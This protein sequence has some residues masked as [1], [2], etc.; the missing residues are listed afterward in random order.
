MKSRSEFLTPRRAMLSAGAAILAL[1][2]APAVAQDQFAG[3]APPD[4]DLQVVDESGIIIRND[5]NPNALPPAGNLD[6]GITGVGQMTIRANPAN[7]N[8]NLCTGTLI[9][10]RV[11]IFAAHCVNTR[12]ASAYGENGT[13]FGPHTG[14]TPIAFG[15]NAD[16][17]PAVR[18]WLGLES[19]PG[20]G[21][22]NPALVGRTNI[23][24]AL[25][26]VEQVWWDPRS[27]NPGSN[28]FIIGDIALATLDT[29]AFDIPTWALL[30]SPLTGPTDALLIGYG[31][32]GNANSPAAQVAID[33]RRRTAENIISV[34]GS[35]NDRNLWL[36]GSAGPVNNLY[37]TSFSDP[38]PNYNPAAGR[39]DFGV[40]GGPS[41]GDAAR[42]REGTTSGGDSGGPLVVQNKYDQQV[43]A[44]V[45]S[46]GSRFFAAQQFHNYGT[47]D[48]FQ[49]LHAY[50]DVIV[51]NNSYVYA[52]NKG[53]D[54][55]WEDPNH[56]VQLMDPAYMIDVNGQLVNSLP[57]TAPEG[58]SGTGAK[59]GYICFLDDCTQLNQAAPTG[60]GTPF[61]VEGGP[62]S[63]N[64]VPNNVVANPRLGIRSRYYDVTLSAPGRTTLSS[65]VTIDRMTLDGQTRLDVR[66]GGALNVLGEFNQIEGWTNVDGLIHSRR[67]AFFLTGLLSGTGTLRA[68]F[69]TV[70]SAI[71][72]PGGADRIGTLT[73]D[74]NLILASASALF[75]DANRFG[76]DRLAVTGALSINGTSLVMNKAQ[77]AAP[78]HGDAFVIASA[79]N[80]VTGTFGQIYAFQGVLRPELTYGPNTV[81]ATLRAGSL[82]NQIGQSGPT[83]R[84]FAR[85]LD[86]LRGNYYTSLYGLYGMVDLMSPAALSATLRGLAPTMVGETRTLQARQSR[87][88]LN[89]VGDRLSSLGS[90]PTGRL[91]VTG[92]AAFVGAL[93]SGQGA[94][95]AGVRF[96]GLV[97]SGAASGALPNGMTGFVS[98]GYLEGGSV[99]GGDRAG[100]GQ[101]QRSWHVA[102]GLEVE[103]APGFTIGSAFGFADGNAVPGA[104]GRS[105]A[106]TTQAAAYGSYRLGG[107]AYVAGLASAD[108]SRSYTER[109]GIAP[110]FSAT[111]IGASDTARYGAMVEAG[112]NLDAWR[113]LTLTPRAALAYQSVH[114]A[115]FRERGSETALQLDDLKVNELQARFGA[116][117]GGEMRLAGGWALQPQL[118]GDY[119]RSL[120]GANA[121]MMVRFANAPEVAFALPLVGGDS[122]WGELRGG[123]R[124]TNGSLSFGAGVET[125]IGRSDW[126]D[127][128]AVADVAFRF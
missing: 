62:G 39:F 94:D 66:S 37:M 93:A 58:V 102:M 117:L 40:F 43:V 55:A 10:P 97:P 21:D 35:L 73:V 25:Y 124:L 33:W 5:I 98:S 122:Q 9:N 11:V 100:L 19:T 74:G 110:D 105:E 123:L 6:S 56:W 112:V 45:L 79:G 118:R 91:D 13:P 95:S 63:T 125:S 59:F 67:D 76:A 4:D 82:A 26:A 14:G 34:L 128:R 89:T 48:F 121:G 85:A 109:A 126:T 99:T 28:G 78:R 57:D 31:N 72:A 96:H 2:S 38:N 17:L 111:L 107:G 87:A 88:L 69:T 70:V 41:R 44:G 46:G 114:Y 1:V 116:E 71:V 68:P 42:Q 24:R 18:Q 64:F 120:A 80:G 15:F 104:G 75:V 36:F 81:T 92:S 8:M 22:A 47:H 7:T 106:R 77:G 51:A 65:A 101:G 3:V 127:R 53:G 83:E 20:A 52:G 115:G 84:A 61:F 16:N 23:A 30:F 108:I 60:N 86:Q 90:G 32:R 12:P 49:P 119:V 50:W 103:A 54:G 29:P 27:L 113:G